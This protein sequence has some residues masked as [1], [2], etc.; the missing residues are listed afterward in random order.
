MLERPQLLPG[1]E[2]IGFAVDHISS[3]NF[4]WL[5]TIAFYSFELLFCITALVA[6]FVP[7]LVC[8]LGEHFEVLGKTNLFRNIIP[9]IASTFTFAHSNLIKMHL[10]TIAH[11]LQYKLA[12]AIHCVYKQANGYFTLEL[13]L[14]TQFQ[15]RSHA[16]LSLSLSLSIHSE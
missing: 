10:L 14:F 11:C 1:S 15:H 4:T 6:P 13:H 3:L 16:L 2:V 5:F 9:R 8:I 12:H 7:L